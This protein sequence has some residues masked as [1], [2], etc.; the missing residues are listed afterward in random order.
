MNPNRK[1]AIIVGVLFILA[2]VM[3]IAS[4]IFIG[5][6][7]APDYLVS[8]AANENQVLTGMLVQTIW[9]LAVVGIP[10]MLCPILRKYNEALALG[11][12]S[13]RLIEGVFTFLG[14]LFQLSLLT[15]SK[16]FVQAGTMGA[17]Y[18]LASGTLLQAARGWA[19]WIGPSIAFALSA[20]ILNNALYQSK[21]VPRWLSG[22]GFIGAI[23]Y[24]PAELFALFGIN[25]FM[26]LAA[27]IALQEMALAI[28]LIAKGFNFSTIPSE[29]SKTELNE[30]K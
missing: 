2:T 16:E 3:S 21:L 10:V 8:V 1:T 5:P 26:F 15:L 30:I 19:F 27:L 17:T 12:F 28:W 11:F 18:Y 22:W 29:S 25:Q 4:V 13:L 14:I 9:A 24:I 20:L 23:V 6:L 7:D